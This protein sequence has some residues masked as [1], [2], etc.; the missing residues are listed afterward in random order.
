MLYRVD[1]LLALLFLGFLAGLL[2]R[3][4]T[5]KIESSRLARAYYAAVVVLVVVRIAVY[6]CS[7]FASNTSMLNTVGGA[8]GDV[9][10]VLFGFLFGVAAR[11]Q[12]QRE[13]LI[14]EHV[15]D[16]L[17]MGLAFGF[18][19][20]G[21]A[22]ALAIAPLIE[23]FRQSGYSET[24]LKFIIAAEIFGAL[25]LLLPWARIPA[26]IGLTV[27]MFG[28]VLT[29][30]HNGDPLNDSTGA[31]GLLIRLITLG[32]LWAW[33]RK[34]SDSGGRARSSIVAVAAAS[35]VCLLVAAGGSAAVRHFSPPTATVAAPIAK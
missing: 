25:G 28:A 1:Y 3:R 7:L 15:L 26:L 23:F 5:N 20:A 22:K 21:V 31:I 11:R 34:E 4:S 19:L 30:V 12:N 24:F 16:A 9:S 10:G 29:H 13:L 17:C 32:V 18:A 14:D 35:V 2:A 33:S 6:I 27:D 8:V